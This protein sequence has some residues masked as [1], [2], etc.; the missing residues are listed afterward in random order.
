MNERTI[1]AT[2]VNADP[3][4]KVHTSRENFTMLTIAQAV[5]LH[6]VLGNALIDAGR[7]EYIQVGS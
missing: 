6:R 7:Y 5:D 4:V 1:S 2:V 3:M